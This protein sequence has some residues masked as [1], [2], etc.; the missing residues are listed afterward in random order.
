V[1]SSVSVITVLLTTVDGTTHR[2]CDDILI[3]RPQLSTP[4]WKSVFGGTVQLESGRRNGF[5][6]AVE[7]SALATAEKQ[8]TMQTEVALHHFG[9]A[10]MKVAF[11][12]TSVVQKFGEGSSL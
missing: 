4:F 12:T 7:Q 11:A 1:Q 10:I 5:G 9:I 8:Y 2:F 6:E 3:W